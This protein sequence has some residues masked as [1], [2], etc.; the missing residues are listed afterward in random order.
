MYDAK[1]FIG[2]GCYSLVYVVERRDTNGKAQRF[3]LKRTFFFRPSAIQCAIRERNVF[4]RLH[5]AE[6]TSPFLPTLYHSFM[7]GQT[8]SVLVL[9][10]SSGKDLSDIVNAIGRINEYAVLFY[11]AEIMCALEKLHQLRIVHMDLKPENVILHPSGHIMLSD[12]DRSN[13]LSS[14]NLMKSEWIS[15]GGTEEFMAPEVVSKRTISTAADI[16]GLGI[17]TAVLACGILS[18]SKR[19]ASGGC[20]YRTFNFKN[21][22]ESLQSFIRACLSPDYNMRPEIA[23]LKSHGFFRSVDWDEANSCKLVVPYDPFSIL[24]GTKPVFHPTD[25]K[26]LS[27]ALD[28]N[29]PFLIDSPRNE[30]PNEYSDL[31][32]REFCDPANLSR[33][34]ITTSRIEEL[35]ADFDFVHRSFR[36]IFPKERGQNEDS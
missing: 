34:G 27:I 30:K 31:F 28:E 11:V 35:F 22:S 4:K 36:D 5:E 10:L 24:R 9:N 13:D 6:I 32:P 33:A 23:Q 29:P 15:F 8:S 16:W 26:I 2:Q 7:I 17:V 18:P 21:L 14:E 3:T 25:A 19:S 1:R 12:F 20:V